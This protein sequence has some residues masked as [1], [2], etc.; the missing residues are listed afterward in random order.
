[1]RS[2]DE[3]IIVVDSSE[4]RKID[5]ADISESIMTLLAE[6]VPVQVIAAR[7]DL[8]PERV[9]AIRESM[10]LSARSETSYTEKINKWIADTDELIALAHEAARADPTPN[11]LYAYTATVDCGVSLLDSADGRK[12]PKQVKEELRTKL[13]EPLLE[14]LVVSTAEALADANKKILELI[15]EDDKI[16]LKTALDN[17]LRSLAAKCAEAANNM[18]DTASEILESKKKKKTTALARRPK[19]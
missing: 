13:M 17:V 10:A 16:A 3:T 4:P 14:Q 18:E 9:L 19:R 6:N 2:S 15:D 7:L 8:D 5:S 1:M 11:N 12:D